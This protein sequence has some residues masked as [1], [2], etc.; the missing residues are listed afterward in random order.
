MEEETV[1]LLKDFL[2][3]NRF[4][5]RSQSHVIDYALQFFLQQKLQK[6][7]YQKNKVVN[8]AGENDE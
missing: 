8:R 1:L 2:R 6:K 5:Y 4:T 3:K 7:Y